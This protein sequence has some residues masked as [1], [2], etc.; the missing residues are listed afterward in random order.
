MSL[1]RMPIVRELVNAMPE[2]HP[3]SCRP[4]LVLALKA[5]RERAMSIDH[6]CI[7]ETSI[8]GGFLISVARR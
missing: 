1:L 4:L 7:A 5:C 2:R 6:S 3:R 8:D